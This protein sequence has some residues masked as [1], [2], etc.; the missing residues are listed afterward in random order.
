ML[1][2]VV[3]VKRVV[4]ID[5][6]RVAGFLIG[7]VLIFELICEMGRGVWVFASL[8]SVPRVCVSCVI[9]LDVVALS[10]G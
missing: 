10:E 8:S 5:L 3:V 1:V 7:S 6:L 9:T 2:E 4:C